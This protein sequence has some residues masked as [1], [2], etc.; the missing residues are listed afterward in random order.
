MEIS[1]KQWNSMYSLIAFVIIFFVYF[2]EACQMAS[3]QKI[4]K[5]NDHKSLLS[6]IFLSDYALAIEYNGEY[7]YKSVHLY[8]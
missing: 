7:H 8:L 4:H 6:K 3:F 5:E 2:L 1:T